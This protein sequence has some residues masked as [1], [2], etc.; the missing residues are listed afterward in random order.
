MVCTKNFA[1][2]FAP[3]G[4]C[5]VASSGITGGFSCVERRL[6]PVVGTSPGTLGRGVGVLLCDTGL[7]LLVGVDAGESVGWSSPPP[8]VHP[9]NTRGRA[10]R[11]TTINSR[12]SLR[13]RQSIE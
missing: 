2:A 6:G 1:N 10:N 4:L 3:S 8:L 11:T 7:V 12:K 13:T 9:A 5:T